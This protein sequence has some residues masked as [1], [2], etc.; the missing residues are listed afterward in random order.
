MKLPPSKILNNSN[1]L[2]ALIRTLRDPE[3]H[4][5]AFREAVEQIG[6][7]LASE[8]LQ[9]LATKET[10][11][12]TSTGGQATHH[13]VDQLPVLAT[14]LR[15]GLPLLQGVQRIFPRAE[16]GFFAASRDEHTAQAKTDYVALPNV[17]GRTVILVDTMLATGGSALDALRI[18]E[19]QN[20]KEVIVLAAIAAE[21]GIQRIK[22][23]NSTI[24]VIAAVIDPVLNDRSFIVPGL[25]DA[26]DRSYG[27]KCELS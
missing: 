21:R 16:V 14:I 23:F 11:V 19:R 25:G 9:S 15:A 10:S 13:I 4:S 18:I 20:P 5:L 26:G 7:A 24:R 22:E 8:V 12:T 17:R 1:L 6:I 27:A 3:T 2:H